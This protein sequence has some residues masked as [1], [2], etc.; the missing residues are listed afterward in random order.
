[1]KPEHDE[2]DAKEARVQLPLRQGWNAELT[3]VE[4]GVLVR[5]GR[6]TE[7]S[8]EITIALTADG[9][10]IRARAAALQ[11]ESTGELT[12]TCGRFRLEAEESVDIVSGGG[13]TLQ[14][15]RL[16]ALATHGSARLKAN[17]DVQLLGENV[18]LNCD[19]SVS[20]PMPPWA[21]PTVLE[22]KELPAEAVSGDVELA[23][24]IEGHTDGAG[25]GAG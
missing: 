20:A 24:E 1:M 9:P 25:H 8:L 2:S 10:V 4:D 11:I 17:D 19:R 13:L 12:A 16:D 6:A 23:P 14:G 22:A 3:R 15:R 18:L 5:V 7:Q 21:L